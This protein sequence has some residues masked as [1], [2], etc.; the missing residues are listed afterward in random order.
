MTTWFILLLASEVWFWS[1]CSVT[2]NLV[3]T[4]LAKDARPKILI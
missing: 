2:Y 1:V 3:P 4:F